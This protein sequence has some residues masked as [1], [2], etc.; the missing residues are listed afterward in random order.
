MSPHYDLLKSALNYLLR[1]NAND[2]GSAF[3]N[4][5]WKQVPKKLTVI[6]SRAKTNLDFSRKIET[7]G[8]TNNNGAAT[9]ITVD[10]KKCFKENMFQC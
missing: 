4:T 7:V 1:G 2:S 5:S 6:E 3:K 9:L 8:T 10:R